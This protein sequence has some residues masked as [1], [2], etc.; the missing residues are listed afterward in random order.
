MKH[1]QRL[2]KQPQGPNKP[3][4]CEWAVLKIVLLCERK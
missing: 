1:R 2:G 3:S 4:L